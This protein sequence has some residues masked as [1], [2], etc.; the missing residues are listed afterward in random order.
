MTM[1]S[2]QQLANS[3]CPKAAE[4]QRHVFRHFAFAPDHTD[5]GRAERLVAG[6][7]EEIGVQI[8]HV[9]VHVRD[10][11]R[12][13]HQRF[14]ASVFD[15]K[16]DGLGGAE[17]EVTSF[18]SGAVFAGAALAAGVRSLGRRPWHAFD[19][20]AA[21]YSLALQA[22]LSGWAAHATA[23]FDAARLREAIAL[24]ED[25]AIQTLIAIGRPGDAGLLP[26]ALQQREHP[27]AR[28]ALS[29]SV[30]HGRFGD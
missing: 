2:K 19:S 18:T 1:N 28:R 13:V 12:T 10:R 21:W 3:Y 22:S 20:G 27:N 24:P 8:L 29:A 23:G 5:A 7:H 11:W 4:E 26:E 30:H 6:K 17:H 14:G 9:H 16:V 25:Y 15:H